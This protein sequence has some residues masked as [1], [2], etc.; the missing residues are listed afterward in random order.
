MFCFFDCPPKIK[1]I[2]LDR[3]FNA[4]IVAPML[5]DFESLIN[6]IPFLLKKFSNLCSKLTKFNKVVNNIFRNFKIII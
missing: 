6:L 5:V 1:I 2:G 3:L 4:A